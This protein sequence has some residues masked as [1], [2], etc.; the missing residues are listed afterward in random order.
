MHFHILR[1][2]EAMLLNNTYYVYNQLN[3]NFREFNL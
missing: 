3:F 1:Y 2:E